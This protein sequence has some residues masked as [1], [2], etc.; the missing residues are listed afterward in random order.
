MI[1]SLLLG[2]V[3]GWLATAPVFAQERTVSGTVTSADDG[4]TL[5]GVSVGVKG[6]ANG[7]ITGI[8]GTY[9]L[10]VPEG[11]TLV[12]SFIGLAAQEIILG[13]QTVLNVQMRPTD[14]A[15]EEF[16][17]TGY[18]TEKKRNIIGP[19]AIV[20]FKDFKEIPVAGLDQALQ[21]QAAG[22]LVTQS[23]GTP[24]GG[25]TVRIRG[26]TSIS[27]GN[28]PIYIIDGVRIDAG[29]LSGRDFG[30]QNDNVLSTINP[31]DIE[32][33]T[34]LKDAAT[35]AIYGASAGNGV[36]VIT[37]KRG[38]ANAKTSLSFDV[39][40][41][42]IDPV[43]QLELLSASQLLELQREAVTNAGGNPDAQGLIPGVT[44]AVDTDWQDEVLRTGI[45]QQYQLSASGGDQRT[46]FYTNLSYRDEEGVQLNNRFERYAGTFN[47]DH[48]VSK[49]LSFGTNLIL[50]RTK[51]FR[52][53]GDNFLDGV[54]SGA[55]KSLPYYQPYDEQG[56][57]TGPGS[58]EY[59]G[60]P[61]FNPVGQ[62]LLP[63]FEVYTL[64]IVGGLFAE[65]ELLPN[66]RLRTKFSADYTNTEENQYE[67]SGTAIGGFLTSVGGR[68]YGV[69]I[70]GTSTRVMNSTTLSYTRTLLGNHNLSGYVGTEVIQNTGRGSNVS[71]RLF[72]SDDF[73]YINSAGIVDEGGSSYGRSGLFSYFGQFKY[74]YQEKYLFSLIGR[75]DGSSNFGPGRRYGFFPSASAG[76]RVSAEPF[77]K[78]LTWVSDL[79]LRASFG[80]T[81]NEAIGSYGFLGL[82]G[83]ATYNGVSGTVPTSLSNENLQWEQT[84]EINAGL[85]ATLFD[86]R[87]SAS[88][89]AYTNLTTKLLLSQPLPL[90]TGFGGVIGNIGSISNRGLEFALTT[91][92]LDGRL[93]W[94]TTLNLSKNVNRVESL[95]DTLP[96]F[97]GYTANGAGN[98]NVV[99]VGQPLGSFWGLNFL[100]VDPATGDALYD[101]RNGDGQITPDDA[102]VIG[103]AQPDFIG[104]ITNRFT[105]RG[106]DLNV[107]F[108]FSVGNEVLN[109][110]KT[111]FVNTGAD[112]LNN[113]SVEAAK[114]WRREG[115]I[116]SVPRYEEG[117][118]FNN[119]HSNR[120]IEDA[121]YLRL[122]NLSVGYTLP[123]ALAGRV[124]LGSVRV[125]A[126]GTNLLTFTNYTG[127]D[128]EVSTLDGSTTAQGIDFFTLP[129]VRTLMVGVTV[130][131]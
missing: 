46:R 34:V 50:S 91:V 52:V 86:G 122:K 101:D 21:G 28:R 67:P 60:F 113:Q 121:T 97:R 71:G 85:D 94:T 62:A 25:I 75:V 8:D 130:G 112:L 26:N 31:N 38:S 27:A 82:F 20:N 58:G 109:F 43:R 107:F 29:G 102:G 100:G 103:N 33:I 39:Q 23:S 24:G 81:G 123:N 70:T 65:Y 17:V 83:A 36:V 104:G 64:K 12:F 13:N 128:P 9:R 115:D 59:A 10:S 98:T 41:G 126:S 14:T 88:F 49:K 35:K 119:Y 131:F 63:R 37:T 61:N 51:N 16:V 118:T 116:T 129:Q 114:R 40:R 108:Q 92:N 80:F 87:V 47:L 56:R 4:A 95:P 54:Y 5:P 45:Y 42:M 106:F 117:N 99:L 32:S 66:L 7:V 90:T 15:L 78:G 105:Y 18:Q 84:R 1:R 69:Y 73:S 2:A 96:L 19:V 6:T 3:L 120:F 57:L 127:S 124:K 79:K 68:G 30:G 93:K 72:P 53:K 76:W 11:A 74:D 110:S 55:V 89:D 125:Y 22:V 44:D 48:T 77:M 111:T